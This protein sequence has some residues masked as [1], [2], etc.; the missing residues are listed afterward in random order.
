ML[1]IEF[2]SYIMLP[3]IRDGKEKLGTGLEEQQSRG[4]ERD[5]EGRIV[6]ILRNP[7]GTR[8]LGP[9]LVNTQAPS[10]PLRSAHSGTGLSAAATSP[11]VSLVGFQ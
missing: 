11:R 4:R 3:A 1:D 2:F 10:R 5:S 9:S 7:S 6:Q 8:A